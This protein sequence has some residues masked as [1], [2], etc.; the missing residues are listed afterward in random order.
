MSVLAKKAVGAS[1]CGYA[2]H[3]DNG[4]LN[5]GKAVFEDCYFFSEG[6]AAAGI[7]TR[8]GCEIIFRNCIFESTFDGN[9]A[10]FFH[11]DPNLTAGGNQ[12]L[13]FENCI[14]HSTNG[15]ALHI[16]EI[17]G[18]NNDIVLTMINCTLYSDTLGAGDSVVTVDKSG[19]T[20]TLVGNVNLTARS[21]GNNIDIG[22]L[23]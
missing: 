2:L 17:G 18:D 7:G 23:L 6:R 8:P 1:S 11:N 20:G 9:G 21:H 15:V 3:L 12:K 5:N 10:V 16:Q 22:P 19:Y 4:W 14:F 13:T